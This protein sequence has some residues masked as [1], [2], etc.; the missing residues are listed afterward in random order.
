VDS[1]SR[2]DSERAIGDYLLAERLAVPLEI[3]D[4]QVIVPAGFMVVVGAEPLAGDKLVV[5]VAVDV[6]PD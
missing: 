3:I 6:R 1:A 4:A 5:T 2:A